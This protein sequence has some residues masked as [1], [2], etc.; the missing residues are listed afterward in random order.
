MQLSTGRILSDTFAMA[1]SRFWSLVGMYLAWFAISMALLILSMVAFG[2]TMAAASAADPEGLAAGAGIA[3]VVGMIVFYLGYLALACAQY[4]AMCTLASPMRSGDFGAAFGA[5]LKAALPLLGTMVVLL[6]GYFVAAIVI[7]V[8]AGVAGQAGT[9]VLVAVLALVAVGVLWLG[10]RIGIVF[11]LVPVE[12]IY[13]PFRAIGRAWA[14]TRGNAWPI[15]LSFVAFM[16]IAA[17]LLGLVLLPFAGTVMAIGSSDGGD[18]AALAGAMGSMAFMFVGLV[19][20]GIVVAIAYAALL[21]AIH[22]ALAGGD[23]AAAAFA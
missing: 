1:K 20:V 12:G 11:P 23:D 7:G 17:V 13:N 16:L 6:V 10:A 8:V 3:A 4:G 21:S 5:G 22:G 15:F 18:P 14:L 9:V 19:V 2:G